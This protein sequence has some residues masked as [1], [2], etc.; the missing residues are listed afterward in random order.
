M[1]GTSCAL[2]H[3]K[4]AAGFAVL[5]GKRYCIGERRPSCFEL[6]QEIKI[7]D[8]GRALRLFA[9][10]PEGLGLAGP[11]LFPHEMTIEGPG[12]DAGSYQEVSFQGAGAK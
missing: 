8:D 6:A 11:L 9:L 10:I 1:N 2:C 7:T 5:G 4:L 12:A 3:R